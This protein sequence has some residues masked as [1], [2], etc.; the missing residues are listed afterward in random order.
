MKRLFGEVDNASETLRG[1]ILPAG[2][3]ARVTIE[4]RAGKHWRKSGVVP[5]GSGGSYAVRLADAG[6]YRVVYRGLA[7]PSVRVA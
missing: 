6:V 1:T 7:G 2:R 4:V 3:G 5:L